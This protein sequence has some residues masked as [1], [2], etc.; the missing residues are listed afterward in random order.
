MAIVLG[1]IISAIAP[2]MGYPQLKDEQHSVII[3]FIAG[4]DAFAV[5]PTGL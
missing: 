4:N 2:S 5:L 1:D 3:N